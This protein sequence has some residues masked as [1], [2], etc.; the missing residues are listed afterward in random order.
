[1]IDQSQV[2]IVVPHLGG[3]KESEYSLDQCLQSL[4]E[5]VPDMKRIVAFNGDEICKHDY[6]FEDVTVHSQGQ[7]KAVNAAVATV[8]TPWVFITNDDMVYAPG[9]WEDLTFWITDQNCCISP[10]L[11][12]PRSGAPSFEVFFAGGAGGDFNKAKWLEFAKNYNH[13]V[14]T[15]ESIRSGFNLPFLVK[16]EVFDLVGGYSIQYDPWSASS[17]T[18]LQC[19]FELAGVKTLQNTNSIVYHFSQTS[20]TFE[21]RNQGDWAKNYG[22]FQE[23]WGF[24]RPGDPDV[25]FSRNLIKYDQL[26]YHP[27]WQDFYKKETSEN[28]AELS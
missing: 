8:N 19:K 22:Y 5:T 7:C 11:I 26:N 10:K 21:P 17:D 24:E 18:D 4:Q 15:T 27:W 20:G 13:S 14:P 23:V 3:T 6:M 2:T 16:K 1:M 12:E 25:W 28:K 9:W